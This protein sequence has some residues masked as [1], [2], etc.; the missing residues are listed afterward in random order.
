M[1]PLCWW[2]Y[3][4]YIIMLFVKKINICALFD[5]EIMRRLCIIWRKERICMMPKKYSLNR[6]LINIYG[7][8]F[9]NALMVLS[10]VYAVFMQSHGI[11]D[12]GISLLL[13]LWSGAIIITQFPL[14]WFA[15]KCG[16]KNVLF[17]GQ[18]F[19]I[20]AFAM[21]VIW[22][23]FASFAIG[24]ALWGMQG[25]I[26]D[27]VS[28][29]VLYDEVRARTHE[30][31]YAK[32]LGRRR[33]IASVAKALSA[34]GSLLLFFG[35]DIIT[36][37]TIVCMIISMLFL[38][39]MHLI[40][41]YTGAQPNVS[42]A[43][44]IKN[45][46]GAFKQAPLLIALMALCVMVTNFSYLNDYLSLIGVDIGLRA[47]FIGI[48][49]FFILCCQVAGQAVAHHFY[50]VRGNWAYAMIIIAGGLFITFAFHYSIVGLV[51]L[52]VAY[53]LCA[54]VR[55]VTY[56]HF[57]D[58]IPAKQRMEVLSFYSITDQATY[59]LIS[60][61]IGLGSLFGS[62]RYSV[63][64]LGCMLGLVGIW[65]MLCVRRG[66]VATRPATLIQPAGIR[67]DGVDAI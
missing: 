1:Q 34:A 3:I 42:L 23:C 43:T 57:Q 30:N 14:T 59:M 7:Y 10:P 25:A 46:L 31:V 65:A 56:A 13:M 39:Q 27:A 15:R 5:M 9:F 32:I 11:S 45:G 28:E 62:W 22:P 29:D 16:A 24:M 55:I 41:K 49:P 60:L 67:P 58:N 53:M 33:N 36:A 18:V 26:Y 44:Q 61:I 19:K 17:A 2:A 8:T 50:N 4:Q 51:A 47:E 48:V 37:L 66:R 63:L 64:I 38:T 52:G 20:I 40:E 21:W 35:Y 54:I 12:M 6:F